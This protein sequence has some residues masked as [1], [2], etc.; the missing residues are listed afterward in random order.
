MT[1][2]APR[3]APALLAHG[4]AA[5]VLGALAFQYWGGL[6]PCV[7]CLWQR[8]PH[9]AAIAAGLAGMYLVRQGRRH[10]SGLATLVAA[11]ALAVTAGLGAYHAGVELRW[12]EGTQAC[13]ATGPVATTAAALRDQLLAAP[14]VRCDEIAWS[15]LGVSMAGWN[16]LLSGALA[17]LGLRG[18][19]GLMR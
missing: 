9:A 4:S 1:P 12:W 13:G 17:L 18:G 5:L 11:A 8:W 15:F 7:L 14:V 16:F 6:Q 2:L 19:L 10:E 3:A